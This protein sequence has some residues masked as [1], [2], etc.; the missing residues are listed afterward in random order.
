MTLRNSEGRLISIAGS[1]GA[2]KTFLAEKLGVHFNAEIIYEHP[3]EGFPDLIKQSFNTQSHLFET[4]LWFRN[5]HIAN[6]LKAKSQVAS[7]K[8]VITDV[9]LYHNQVFVRAYVPDPFLREILYTMGNI[10]R[11][12]HGYPDCTIYIS[13]TQE[14]VREFLTRRT[15]SREWEKDKWFEFM[16]RMP[17]FVDAY[18]NS[19]RSE[20]PAFIEVKRGE[21]DF[22][23][24]T[25][26]LSLVKKVEAVL[27]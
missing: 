21:Y 19:I 18:M 12:Q 7:G 24:E 10:D 2:G 9:P 16:T 11:G 5:R 26:F 27:R 20:I 8:N 14:L 23:V 4:I 13:T 3:R 22:A 17:P 6:Y 15:G 25:D 1:P